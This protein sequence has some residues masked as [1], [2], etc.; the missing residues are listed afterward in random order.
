[1]PVTVERIPNKPI[2]ILHYEGFLDLETVKSAFVQSA[3]LAADIQG[4]IYRV[5]D[6]RNADSNFVEIVN[7]IKASRANVQGNATDTK[8]QV[9][10]V[11]QNQLIHLYADALKQLGAAPIPIF[12]TME[13]AMQ[14]IELEQQKNSDATIIQP[15]D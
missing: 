11:G 3:K 10:F 7:I 13:D 9:I 14:F 5:A 15:A 2:I 4:I 8:F 6:V 1:M 12:H